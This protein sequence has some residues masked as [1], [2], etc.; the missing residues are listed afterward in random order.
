MAA[1]ALEVRRLSVRFGE[2]QILREVSLRAGVG[3]CVAI[4]GP[5]GSGKTTLLR[6][7][8]GLI[9]SEPGGQVI[10]LGKDATRLP[11]WRRAR[12]GLAHLQEGARVFASMTP[13]ENLSVGIGGRAEVRARIDAL[14]AS[15]PDLA[16]VLAHSRSAGVL[17]GGEKQMLALMRAAIRSPRVILLDSPFMGAG[18]RYRD[19]IAQI[20][21]DW[22]SQGNA[23]FVLVDHDLATVERVASTSLRLTSGVLDIRD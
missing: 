11:P 10:L 16:Q 1:P 22:R 18:P 9:R 15:F 13:L 14:A 17:S 6:A 2:R 8:S 23:A 5:N 20:I 21:T 12:L 4:T 19:V 3:E 7:I